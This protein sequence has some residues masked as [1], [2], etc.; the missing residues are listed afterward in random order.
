MDPIILCTG[1][2]DTTDGLE[3]MARQDELPLSGQVALITGASRRIG[4]AVAL[5][6]AA[7]GADVVVHAR[8]AREEVEGVAGEVRALGRKSLALLGDV[9][10]EADVEAI[11]SEV[12]KEFGRL[13]IL[14]NNAAIRGQRPFLEMSLAEWRQINA[15]ILDGAFLCSRE[16]L[17][18]MTEGGGGTIINIGGVTAHVGASKRAHVST[19]KAGLVGLTKA[20][21]VEFAEAG[22]T[23]NCVAPGKIGG[24]R[25]ATSGESADMPGGKSILVGREGKIEEAAFIIASLCMPEARFMTGQTVHVSG[26]LFMP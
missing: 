17:K 21:A 14:I 4:R 12:R 7:A 19:A 3:E 11:F 1:T 23:V 8:S 2:G 16:G 13:D 9:T 10:A 18:I 25:S 20:L 24:Q 5:R 15:V 26:G 22:V 6:L